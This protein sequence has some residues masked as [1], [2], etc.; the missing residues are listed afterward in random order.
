MKEKRSSGSTYCCGQ[1]KA[2]RKVDRHPRVAPTPTRIAIISTPSM[3]ATRNV[4]RIR[5]IPFIRQPRFRWVAS[6]SSLL[7]IAYTAAARTGHFLSAQALANAASIVGSR[8]VASSFVAATRTGLWR[9]LLTLLK[10]SYAGPS[11]GARIFELVHSGRNKT[12]RAFP[13]ADQHLIAEFCRPPRN[14]LTRRVSEQR[15]DPRPARCHSGL[16][17]ALRRTTRLPLDQAPAQPRPLLWGS[18]RRGRSPPS[19]GPSGYSGA[20][21]ARES[22]SYDVASETDGRVAGNNA[23]ANANV[24]TTGKS[25][26]ISSFPWPLPTG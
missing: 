20:V 23:A 14:A 12:V 17:L 25:L 26:F 22:R 6:R 4:A 2:P 11:K 9:S 16:P 15:Q 1:P 8:S 7:A 10:T 19:F 5:S 13:C 21:G 3:V 18:N 24:A